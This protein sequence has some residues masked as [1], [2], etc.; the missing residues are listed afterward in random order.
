M[1]IFYT[2]IWLRYDGT[3]YYIGKGSGNRAFISLC[4]NV[5]RPETDDRILIQEFPS[6]E[7]AFTAERFLISYYGRLDLGTGCLRNM[8]D[9]GE[10]ISGCIRTSEHNAKIGAANLGKLRS[11]NARAK[12]RKAAIHQFSNPEARHK[13]R[14]V[15]K[16][17]WSSPSFVKVRKE[18]R[19]L[20]DP[21]SLSHP[22]KIGCNCKRH[23][24]GKVKRN[25]K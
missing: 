8:T 5:H 1:K 17:S 22:C 20:Q 23:E 12:Y 14:E 19:K 3:P 13:I 2:Y 11:D 24:N 10:G 21:A 15:A 25:E 9:G 16:K 6:E 7:D 18:K 4:H